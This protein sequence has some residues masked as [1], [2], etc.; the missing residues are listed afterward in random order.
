MYIILYLLEI[1]Q[2]EIKKHNGK[3]KY[4]TINSIK[5]K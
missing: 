2:V 1:F 5:L 3:L 4:Y